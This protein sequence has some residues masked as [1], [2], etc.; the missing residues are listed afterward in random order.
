M[1]GSLSL[2]EIASTVGLAFI[3]LGPERFPATRRSRRALFA[4][5]AVNVCGALFPP[6]I[7]RQ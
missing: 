4:T 1:T 3:I 2:F 7:R 6:D 5:L